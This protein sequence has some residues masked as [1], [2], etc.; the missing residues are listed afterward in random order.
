M[1]VIIWL[2]TTQLS[3]IDLYSVK[4]KYGHD[5]LFEELDRVMKSDDNTASAE[6]Q[7]ERK[8]KCQTPTKATFTPSVFC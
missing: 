2:F 7:K 5:I 4:D 6:D 1:Q 3:D 8:L